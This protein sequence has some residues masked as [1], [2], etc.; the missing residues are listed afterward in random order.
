MSETSPD[1]NADRFQVRVTSDSHFSWVR[2]RLAVESTLM[3]WI[4]TSISLIG[5]GFTIVQFFARLQDMEG[6]AEAVR[7]NAPRYIGLAM[8]AAGVL[9]LVIS[10]WQYRYM[11]RYLWSENFAPLAGIA[12]EKPIPTP[13]L[14]ICIVVALIGVFAFGAVFFRMI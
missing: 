5:F 13:I 7:P 4:R 10:A 9:G 1:A 12:G 11:N 6:V 8:I 14:A 3:S 2:T